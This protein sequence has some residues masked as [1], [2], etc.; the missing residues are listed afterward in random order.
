M[1]GE[2]TVGWDHRDRM[3]EARELARDVLGEQA[4]DEI[5]V[6]EIAEQLI[7]ECPCDQ[8]T[9]QNEEN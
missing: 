1:T 3:D 6:Q 2:P 8:C 9:M 4:G 5:L 7:S